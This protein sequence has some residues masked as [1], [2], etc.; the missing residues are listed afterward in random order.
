MKQLGKHT[1][2]HG[3]V[4]LIALLVSSRLVAQDVSY[5]K[6]IKPIIQRS[7]QG[8][9]QPATKMGGLVLTDVPGACRA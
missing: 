9:H 6:D 2:G 5:S 4:A 3:L 8:C 1:L 7:C